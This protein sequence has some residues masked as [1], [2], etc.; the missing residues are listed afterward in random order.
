MTEAC[1]AALARGTGD[2]LRCL[3]EHTDLMSCDDDEKYT[4]CDGGVDPCAGVDC[5]GLAEGHCAANTDADVQACDAVVESPTRVWGADAAADATACNAVGFAQ[6]GRTGAQC[7][8]Y[9]GGIRG[10]CEQLDPASTATTCLCMGHWK[11]GYNDAGG[12][13]NTKC[14]NADLVY[15]GPCWHHAAPDLDTDATG[16][17]HIATCFALLHNCFSRTFKT[18]CGARFLTRNLGLETGGANAGGNM[19]DPS[20]MACVSGEP[21]DPDPCETADL[22]VLILTHPHPILARSTGQPRATHSLVRPA[23]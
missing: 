21:A 6:F 8:Y 11:S 16:G 18:T 14:T 19:K 5:G 4:F 13:C 7:V 3:S 1:G 15:P 17:K 20:I 10:Q 9:P 22:T 2:C 23:Y 12:V